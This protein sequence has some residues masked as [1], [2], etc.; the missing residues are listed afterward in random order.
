MIEIILL[1]ALA[2][3]GMT[4]S[5]LMIRRDLRDEKN[6]RVAL[7]NNVKDLLQQIADQVD[8]STVLIESSNTAMNSNLSSLDTKIHALAA[9]QGLVSVN[10]LWQYETVISSPSAQKAKPAVKKSP[11]A[12]KAAV[13]K[14]AK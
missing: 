4:V 6:A 3:V 8:A 7:Q 12:P 11:V 2:V 13:K 1:L 14:G 9:T 10:G 5:L